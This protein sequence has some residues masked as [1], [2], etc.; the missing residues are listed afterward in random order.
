MSQTDL[1]ILKKRG[2]HVT[3]YTVGSELTMRSVYDQ[4]FQGTISY[5]RNDSIYINGQPFHYKEIAE[6][7]VDESNFANTTMSVGMMAAGAG[8]FILGGVNGLY[9]HDSSKD[10]Y[11][12]S[13]LVTGS[14][15]IVVGYLLTKTRVKH[16][17]IGG[18][19]T[20]DY[21]SLTFNKNGDIRK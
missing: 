2:M 18:K 10:W 15:L 13:G 17:R 20:L 14:A 8:I 19:Y 12:A 4:W 3:T 9:R 5:M 11:T 6:I 1:L 21:L 16:I 7:R